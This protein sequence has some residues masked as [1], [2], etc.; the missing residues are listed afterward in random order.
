MVTDFVQTEHLQDVLA[1]M[2][3]AQLAGTAEAML[4][5]SARIVC[6]AEEAMLNGSG[7]K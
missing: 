3:G 5:V 4:N 2:G 1:S 7:V 6:A